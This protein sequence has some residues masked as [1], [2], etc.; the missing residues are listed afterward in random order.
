MSGMSHDRTRERERE[1]ERERG[2]GNEIES[3]GN[4]GLHADAGHFSFTNMQIVL[5]L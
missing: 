5:P 3:R 4:R 2:G 1:R